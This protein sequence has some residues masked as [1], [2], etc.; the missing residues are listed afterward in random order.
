[1]ETVSLAENQKYQK[2]VALEFKAKHLDSIQ[3]YHEVLSS[4]NQENPECFPYLS[5]VFTRISRNYLELGRYKDAQKYLDQASH[6]NSKCSSVSQIVEGELLIL[7]GEIYHE[8]FELDRALEAFS[9]ATSIFENDK[10]NVRNYV[11][12]LR[13]YASLHYELLNYKK[14]I[15]LYEK[16]ME[17]SKAEL[18]PQDIE[19]ARIEHDLGCVLIIINDVIKSMNYLLVSL[20][21]KKN[22]YGY[23]HPEVAKTLCQL[24]NCYK[25]MNRY[26][27]SLVALQ[28]ALKIFKKF[29][30]EVHPII[31]RTNLELARLYESGLDILLSREYYDKAINMVYQLFEG[32]HP[33]HGEYSLELAYAYHNAEDYEKALTLCNRAL[34]IFK[35]NYG[36]EHPFVAVCYSALCRIKKDMELYDEAL[37]DNE[38]SLQLARKI[39]GEIHP[40][41]ATK[42]FWRGYIYISQDKLPEALECINKMHEIELEYFGSQSPK[43]SRNLYELGRILMDM[44][45][46]EEALEKIQESLDKVK[47]YSGQCHPMVSDRLLDIAITFNDVKMYDKAEEC[48]KEAI[49]IQKSFYNINH[50]TLF[51]IYKELAVTLAAKGDYGQ[52]FDLFEK[53]IKLRTKG[54]QFSYESEDLFLKLGDTCLDDDIMEAANAYEE[55]VGI[56][57][58]LR[59]PRSFTLGALYL[60]LG[61]CLREIDHRFRDSLQ[62]F[63]NSYKI[64]KRFPSMKKTVF[65]CYHVSKGYIVSQLGN[66]EEAI[67]SLKVALCSDRKNV[68]EAANIREQIFA[69]E[70]ME[71]NVRL[72]VEFEV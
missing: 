49:E 56:A 64:M 9:K 37:E 53:A 68:E 6:F 45:R 44:G 15:E 31:A 62:A 28:E 51:P 4:Y 2:A 59:G 61:T 40:E 13:N 41:M 34:E 3:A 52:A 55:A 58:T 54:T 38:K 32:N 29:Y 33:F 35:A 47:E 19:T 22:Y 1:M 27:E 43:V 46:K 14:G 57:K 39:H 26:D 69:A 65:E 63:L 66:H 70:E 23:N 36:E 11:I 12:A 30:G 10:A 42:Y 17:I 8:N 5:K 48:L 72:P 67:R 71:A 20:Y 50:W 7:Q 60:R 25:E 18:G 21:K 24:G 16:A